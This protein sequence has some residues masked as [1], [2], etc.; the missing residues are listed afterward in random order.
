MPDWQ[1]KSDPAV[2]GYTHSVP[3]GHGHALLGQIVAGVFRSLRV[4]ASLRHMKEWWWSLHDEPNLISFEVEHSRSKERGQHNARQ[5]A[6]AQRTRR[7]CRGELLGCFD[8]YVPLCSSRRVIGFLI[9]G[10]FAR[11]RPNATEILERWRR[12]TGRQGH[13]A[14][15]EF[16]SYLSITLGTLV[17]EGDRAQKFQELLVCLGRL[18]AGEGRAD[19]LA[20]RA[21]ALRVE[22]EKVRHCEHTWESV[23]QMVDERSSQTWDGSDRTYTLFRMGL[24]RRP[25]QALVA[26]TTS[27]SRSFDPVDEAVRRDAF[28]RAAVELA[29]SIG[30][31]VAGKVGDHGVVF[32]SAGGG[33]THRRKSHLLDLAA[34][35]ETLARRF[36]LKP[37]FGASASTSAVS[38]HHVYEAALGAAESALI[39]GTRMIVAEPSES[40]PGQSLRHLRKALRG[41]VDE[42]SHSL[43]ARFDRYLE[44][45]ALE[46]GYRV[47]GAR[48]YLEAGFD[49]LAET[50]LASGRLDDKSF[51]ASCDALERAARSAR[52]MQELLSAYRRAAADL[53]SS[54]ERPLQ[55]RHER[56]LRAALEYIDR[57]YTEALDV[58][59]VAR[60]A[61]FTPNY[62][63]KL[64]SA[65]E[66]MTFVDYVSL[67]RVERAKRL[68]SGTDLDATRISELSGFNSPQYFSRVFRRATG[69][70]P[71][72]YRHHPTDEEATA[73][74]WSI[75]RRGPRKKRTKRN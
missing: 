9:A 24:A 27:Q 7:A 57:H 23:R 61:G 11:K 36:A 47:E 12:L 18:I 20:N 33:T 16:A 49:R 75:P 37:H 54:V 62:F 5:I 15:P 44:A 70:T 67:R 17:L 30:G 50:L 22:L 31:V 46:H 43:S 73:E 3:E 10:P 32:L 39:Q 21:D 25:D 40:R 41:A 59:R 42:Q 58:R 69:T 66:K 1:V 19:A 74:T 68:L 35:A 52:T 14:D 65:R 64:F 26:L 34:R 45:V 29:S 28:Q 48:G 51:E 53:S 55:A 4:G 71:L 2:G 13:L 60:V 72:D 63:S 6:K 8:V 38:I 56:G